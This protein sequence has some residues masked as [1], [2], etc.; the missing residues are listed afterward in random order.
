MKYQV[1]NSN[2][3]FVKLEFVKLRDKPVKFGEKKG[4]KTAAWNSVESAK[5]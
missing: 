1:L 3:S 2:D 4:I 5:L